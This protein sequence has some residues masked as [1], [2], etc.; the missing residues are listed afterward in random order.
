[1]HKYLEYFVLFIVLMNSVFM[2]YMFMYS[3]K[4]EHLTIG[5]TVTAESLNNIASIYNKDK[6]ILKDLD[7]TGNLSFLPKGIVVMWTG[8]TPPTGWAL[9]DGTNGTPNLKGRFVLGMGQGTGLAVR[10][11]NGVGGEEK[12]TLTIDEMPSHFHPLNKPVR[13]HTRSFEGSDDKDKP[14]KDSSGN[15]YGLTTNSVGGGK[16]HENMPPFYVLAFIMKL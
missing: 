11:I 2:V 10:N 1:M 4:V 14:L 8:S 13:V 5:D 6:M 16:S 12:H 7:V 3:K 15:D 9:C